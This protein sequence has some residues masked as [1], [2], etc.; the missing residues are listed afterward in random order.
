MAQKIFGI[1]IGKKDDFDVSPST[2]K[3]FALPFFKKKESNEEENLE[4]EFDIDFTPTLPAVNVIPVS[5]VEGYRNKNTIRNFVR[6][7]IGIAGVIALIFAYTNI[8]EFAHQANLTQ[9]ENE[10]QSL[11]KSMAELQPYANYEKE[12]EEK[13]KI[14]SNIM[15]TDVDMQ[16]IVDFVFNT[17]SANSI[18][19]TQMNIKLLS[20]GEGDC[21]SIDPFETT[22]VIGCVTIQGVQADAPALNSF[23]KTISETK[24]YT[25]T[26]INNAQYNDDPTNNSFSGSFSFTADLYSNKY[27]SMLLPI[28]TL[29]ENGI[30]FEAVVL[31][32]ENT[33]TKTETKEPNVEPTVE[34]TPPP[35]VPTTEPSNNSTIPTP[36]TTS[37]AGQ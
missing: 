2:K 35:T 18:R 5:V 31:E 13:I 6:A 8:G 25:S 17:A 4:A 37:T 19:V 9:L 11:Q 12:V 10:G 22:S 30:T 7:G 36:Q 20:S 33:D 34:P 23:F 28:D 32:E 16:K 14:I 29:I 27:N 1:T 3:K 26:F 15:V 21:I 24:G